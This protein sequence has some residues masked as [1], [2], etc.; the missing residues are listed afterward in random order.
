MIR[1]RRTTTRDERPEAIRPR[2]AT[3]V[4]AAAALYLGLDSRRL[5]DL[6]AVGFSLSDIAE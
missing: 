3:V 1:A 6:L 5:R 4:H 2:F